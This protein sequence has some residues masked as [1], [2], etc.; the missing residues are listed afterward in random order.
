MAK[1]RMSTKAAVASIAKREGI[2]KKN[3]AGILAWANA[4][5]NG[6]VKPKKKGKK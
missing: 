3:A 6:T 1:K 4:T 2:S 5:Q